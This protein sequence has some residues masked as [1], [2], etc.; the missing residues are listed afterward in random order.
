MNE[1]DFYEEFAN[2]FYEYLK[3]YLDEK[4]EIYYSVNKTLDNMI[5][6]IETRAGFSFMNPSTYI[7]KLK[8]DIL[9]V[10]VSPVKQVKLILVEAKYLNQLS[11]QHYS[12][13]VGY[14]QVGKD[15]D[16]GLLLLIKRGNTPN[17]LSNDFQE[18]IRLKKLPMNWIM[19][20]KELNEKYTFKT[21]IVNY[22]PSGSIDWID[23]KEISG[24]SSFEEL[25]QLLK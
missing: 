7:P 6:E 10:A 24:I 19:D 3:S 11:L 2:R 5:S 13:L 25:A 21:G 1:I 8:L 9:F 23:T 15:I 4:F 17:K 22:L 12:Q 20:M 14:L 18:I 16:F